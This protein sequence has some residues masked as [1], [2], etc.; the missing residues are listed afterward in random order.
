MIKKTEARF[1]T[2]GLPAPGTF[3]EPLNVVFFNSLPLLDSVESLEATLL[4]F[5]SLHD[6]EA[7]LDLGE[8]RH[9]ADEIEKNTVGDTIYACMDPYA[10]D[11]GNGLRQILVA[12]DLDTLRKVENDRFGDI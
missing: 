4:T 9:L 12:S 7:A 6:L 5:D 3:A 2:A 11:V 8:D 1:S 10:H